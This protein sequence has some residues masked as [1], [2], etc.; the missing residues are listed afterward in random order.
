ME[1]GTLQRDSLTS[2]AVGGWEPD[3]ANDPQDTVGGWQRRDEAREGALGSDAFW[4]HEGSIIPQGLV[5]MTEEEREVSRSCYCV[6][7]VID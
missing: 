2:L 6:A 4:D 3:Q 7:F 5:D 1:S